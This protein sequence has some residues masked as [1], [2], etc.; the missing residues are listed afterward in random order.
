MKLNK[1]IFVAHAEICKTLSNPKR[2]EILDIM[3]DKEVTVNDLVKKLKL[4]KA[5]VSQHLSILRTQGVVLSRRSG[6]NIYYKVSSHKIIKACSLMR[7][8]LMERL[9][10]EQKILSELR[11][12]R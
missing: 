10:R 9:E 2:L 8:V 3:R 11:R 4:P 12:K 1:N 6:R 5:N 7:E